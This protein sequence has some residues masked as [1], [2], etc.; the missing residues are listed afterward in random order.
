MLKIGLLASGAALALTAVGAN[1]T[2]V[3]ATGA[4]APTATQ[5]G[6]WGPTGW[7]PVAG[8]PAPVA[9]TPVAPIPAAAPAPVMA[10]PSPAMPPM[11]HEDRHH[12]HDKQSAYRHYERGQHGPGTWNDPAYAVND[13]SEWGFAQPGPGMHWAR[14]YDDAVLVD[15]YGT[16]VDTR[17]GV[18]WDGPRPGHGYGAGYPQGGYAGQGYAHA[19]TTVTHVGPNTTVT[20]QVYGGGPAYAAGGYGAGYG[21]G[22]GYA[23]GGTVF[24]T[25]GTMTTTTTVTSEEIYKKAW[26]RKRVWHRP[27]HRRIVRRPSCGCEAIRGS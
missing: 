10:P 27:I 8:A 3:P 18:G 11:A 20:T 24:I 22:Y 14:Y 17:Y 13:W 25:P 26:A 21:G 2:T 12:H 15:A 4:P 1:A 9:A 19:G 16:I 5:P 23:S 7:T 6:S